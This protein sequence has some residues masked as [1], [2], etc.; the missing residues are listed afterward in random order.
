[1]EKLKIKPYQGDR[2][3][4]QEKSFQQWVPLRLEIWLL[5]KAGGMAEGRKEN[6]PSWLIIH[7]SE[8]CAML[9]P[10]A[11]AIFST[12]FFYQS[13]IMINRLSQ[14]EKRKINIRVDDCF[15]SCIL[16]VAFN[17]SEEEKE[18]F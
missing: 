11:L 10:F 3:S 15:R 5:E 9:T 12:L 8:S 4:F 7:A 18:F 16:T 2:T 17:G 1:V 13:Y 14:K 6:I